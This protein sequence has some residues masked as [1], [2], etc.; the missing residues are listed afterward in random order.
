MEVETPMNRKTR[1]LLLTACSF[2]LV[3]VLAA[4]APAAAD[5]DRPRYGVSARVDSYGALALAGYLASAPHVHRHGP[6]CAHLP[7]HYVRPGYGYDPR[8]H[9][10][11]GGRGWG[12]HVPAVAV[13]PW[14]RPL[15]HHG[16]GYDRHYDSRG[17]SHCGRR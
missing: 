10:G 11:Y 13:R 5:H 7:G 3:A 15:P 1:T 8:R 12:H 4:P 16:Y 2:S 6:A 9:Y 17:H 14:G